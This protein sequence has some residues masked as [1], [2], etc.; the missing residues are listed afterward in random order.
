[1]VGLNEVNLFNIESLV[2]RASPRSRLR[3][4]AL[5]GFVGKDGE[6]LWRFQ[7]SVFRTDGG[8]SVQVSGFSLY[9]FFILTPDT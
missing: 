7:V 9:F 8:F 6:L 2:L 3:G 5:N 1:M 4:S